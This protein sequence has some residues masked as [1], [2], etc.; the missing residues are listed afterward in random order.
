LFRLAIAENRLDRAR[1]LLLCAFALSGLLVFSWLAR[2]PSV[3]D[4][5]DLSATELG[6]YLLV[7]SVGAL[8]TVFSASALLT[9]FGSGRVFA[10]GS[11]VMSAGFALMG[12]GPTLDSR[13]LFLAGIVINGIGGALI[14][15]PM[16][17]ESARLEQAYG[18]TIIPHFHAAFS[19]GAVAG[20]LLGAV[21]SSVGLTVWLQFTIAAVGVG[22]ARL[23][24]L[25]HGMI[26]P[27]ARLTGPARDRGPSALGVWLQ[28][29]TLLI[30]AVAF[31]AA[32]SEGAA[33][34]WLALAF[35]DGFGTAESSGGLVLGAFIGSMTLV[36]AFGTGMIDRLGRTLSLQISGVLA[37]AGL[38]I[39]GLAPG[40]ATAVAGVCLWGV[41]AAL[42]FPIAVAAASDEPHA[43]A[44]RVSVVASLGSVAAMTAAPLIGF[45]A[46]YLGGARH[47]LLV[48]LVALVVSLAVSRHVSPV[49]TIEIADPMAEFE[50]IPVP[51]A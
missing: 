21:A 50:R 35:V 33:N 9:R 37:F 3:R 2:I 26:L 17:V 8:I 42:C 7:G 43:A 18:R 45:A 1:L 36:R 4:A 12:I 13:P 23:A 11:I 19:A 51:V 22:C 39:F 24:M 6:G 34:N 29:R 41:G 31:A 46:A 49:A 38:A 27:E 20:S 48:V 5:L 28:P 16:N 25:E 30:G 10:T 32:L 44:A 47:A 15:L 40:P 14:N